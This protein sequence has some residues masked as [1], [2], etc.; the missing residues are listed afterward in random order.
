LLYG[1]GRY[2]HGVAI[3]ESATSREIRA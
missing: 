3:G 2:L 1:E